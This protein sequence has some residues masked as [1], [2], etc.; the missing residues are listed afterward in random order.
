MTHPE[1]LETIHAGSDKYN[2]IDIEMER[3]REKLDIVFNPKNKKPFWRDYIACV[4]T[5]WRTDYVYFN[6]DDSNISKIDLHKLSEEYGACLDE[7]IK[8]ILFGQFE[9]SLIK[10]KQKDIIIKKE[11]NNTHTWNQTES[12]ELDLYEYI[13]RTCPPEI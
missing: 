13:D 6:Y 9:Q 8:T 12:W 7:E 3:I 10:N 2:F 11:E 5:E 4:N 1:Y